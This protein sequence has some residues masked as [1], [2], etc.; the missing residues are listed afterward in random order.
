MTK[1]LSPDGNIPPVI[2]PIHGLVYVYL[3]KIKRKELTVFKLIKWI[4]MLLFIV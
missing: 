2:I 3:N 4:S 1:Y